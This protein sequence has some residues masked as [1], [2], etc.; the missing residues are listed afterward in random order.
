MSVLPEKKFVTPDEY[1]EFERAAL[2]KHEY[3]NG[4]IF[5]MS[6][7]SLR[8]GRISANITTS[9]GQQFKKG[10]C[11]VFHSDLR[12]HIPRTGLFT[13]PDIIVVC[14]NPQLRDDAFLD[15]LL[16][17]DMILEVL[18]PS[19]QDYDRGDKFEHYRTVESLKEYVLIWQD[20]KRAARYS[21]QDSGSW[22]LTDFIGEDSVIELT[23]VKGLLSFED[24]YDKVKFD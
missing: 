3:L 7:A 9:F 19:T 20:K 23:S 8:H 12:V 6:G 18:S 22:V 5:A 16:N 1:L 4:E 13:Y 24:I 10:S 15:T 11:E 14:G 2:E 21:K 17:P